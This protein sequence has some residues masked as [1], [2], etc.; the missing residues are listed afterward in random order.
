LV[1]TVASV[2]AWTDFPVS[3]KV[4]WNLVWWKDIVVGLVSRKRRWYL[5]VKVLVEGVVNGTYVDLIT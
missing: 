1:S 5:I 3:L 4:E 2:L